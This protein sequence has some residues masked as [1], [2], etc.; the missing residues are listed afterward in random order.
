MKKRKP[1]KIVLL[2]STLMLDATSSLSSLWQMFLKHMKKVLLLRVFLRRHARI[3]SNSVQPMLVFILYIFGISHRADHITVFFRRTWNSWLLWAISCSVLVIYFSFPF[4][5]QGIAWK[6][7][8]F[9]SGE[10]TDLFCFYFFLPFRQQRSHEQIITLH[11]SFPEQQTRL[12]K[13]ISW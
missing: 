4:H 1:R 2:R 10:K 6:S 12:T 11:K 9:Y 8:L 7:N 13:Q 5:V 3:N